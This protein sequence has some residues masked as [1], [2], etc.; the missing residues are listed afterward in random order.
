MTSATNYRD[1]NILANPY[2]GTM[3]IEKLA[4]TGAAEKVVY[5]FNTGSRKD[6]IANSGATTNGTTEGQYTKAIPAN[7]AG[8]VAGMP[9]QIPSLSSFM[10]KST[11]AGNLKYRYAD[12][13][14]ATEE[15]AHPS[16]TSTPWLSTSKAPRR[17]TASG[18]FKPKAPPI[19][20]TTVGTVR[21]SSH[22]AKLPSTLCKIAATR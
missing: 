20:T 18:S 19:A 2:T 14:T 21:R 7:L 17:P 9:N 3:D 6:W 15:T 8:H 1:M 10:V 16:A 4:F 11:A 22:P 5:L 12:L 13:V